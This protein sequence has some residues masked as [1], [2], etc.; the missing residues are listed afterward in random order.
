[1][2]DSNNIYWWGKS[3]TPGTADATYARSMGTPPSPVVA[4]ADTPTF[5]IILLADQ[6]VWAWPSGG[7]P[8]QVGWGGGSGVIA[9]AATDT[10]A[11]NAPAFYALD[12]SGNISAWGP[13]TFFQDNGLQLIAAAT[14]PQ[15]VAVY[16]GHDADLYALDAQGQL[17]RWSDLDSTLANGPVTPV[18]IPVPGSSGKLVSFAKGSGFQLALDSQGTVWATGTNTSGQLGQGDNLPHAGFVPVGPTTEVFQAV[19]AGAE[20][21]VALDWNGNGL[22]YYNNDGYYPSS[23][24]TWGAN[25]FG[26]LGNFSTAAVGPTP[27]TGLESYLIGH[28]WG[29]SQGPSLPSYAAPVGTRGDVI[30]P[31][32]F[33]VEQSSS[34]PFL[35]WGWDPGLFLNT[36]AAPSDT[37]E[38]GTFPSFGPGSGV[39]PSYVFSSSLS[40]HA[41]A[42]DSTGNLRGW[43]LNSSGQLCQTPAQDDPM[44]SIGVYMNT[45][46]LTYTAFS[47][48][49]TGARNSFAID[50]SSNLWAWGDNSSA[51]LGLNGQSP[52]GD[53][54]VYTGPQKV[55]DIASETS[56]Y[57]D[58]GHETPR[59]VA[60][61]D[62]FTVLL[63]YD[64]NSGHNNLY[65]WGSD[66]HGQQGQGTSGLPDGILY[67]PQFNAFF[68]TNGISLNA[69]SAGTG[70]QRQR[71]GL[72]QQPVR[73]GGEWLFLRLVHAHHGAESGE[74]PG[75][76]RP[77]LRRPGLLAGT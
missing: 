51:Q 57:Q 9:L 48:A 70:Q 65:T 4:L 1:V 11:N 56:F 40:D 44:P 54:S 45:H 25:G 52:F 67:A 14:N 60:A 47:A 10:D 66:Q 13:G 16:A 53:T 31:G 61:G 46:S 72:G 19:A 33:A 59:A 68:P 37:P 5:S 23:L 8:V 76:H 74:L 27:M 12:R 21:G 39:N 18:Q 43:G 34:Q 63:T 49:F 35:I 29:G 38:R 77:D 69:I 62:D 64:S 20:F 42:L 28:G 41:L 22:G 30:L 7:E 36:A 2:D 32:K 6:S 24:W 26:E 75:T 3:N 55:A 58:P 71:L 17:W 50:T 73:A 15:Y